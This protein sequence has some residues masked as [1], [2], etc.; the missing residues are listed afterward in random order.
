MFLHKR[1][2]SNSRQL[3]RLYRSR[4]SEYRMG[5]AKVGGKNF[6]SHSDIPSKF[7]TTVATH[8]AVLLIFATVGL[9]GGIVAWQVL[10]PSSTNTPPPMEQQTTLSCD[11]AETFHDAS[12]H[13][14]DVKNNHVVGAQQKIIHCRELL[15]K[16]KNAP[17]VTTPVAR[18]TM[19]VGKNANPAIGERP[20]ASPASVEPN[21][22]TFAEKRH[23]IPA[24]QAEQAGSNPMTTQDFSSTPVTFDENIVFHDEHDNYSNMDSIKNIGLAAL[25]VLAMDTAAP[26]QVDTTGYQAPDK[27]ETVASSPKDQSWKSQF[28]RHE[29]TLGVGDPSRVNY[30]R[31]RVGTKPN[32]YP[33]VWLQNQYH[34]GNIY[35]TCPITLGY[36]FRVLK[37]LWVGGDVSY[38]G[39]FGSFKDVYTDQKVGKYRDHFI[40]IMPA[41]R[42]SSLYREHFAMY[43]GIACGIAFEYSESYPDYKAHNNHLA[44][45]LTLLGFTAGNQRW[46]GFAEL[47][48]GYKGGYVN[49]GLGFRFNPKK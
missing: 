46:F 44:F 20:A 16:V 29:F 22:S 35:T 33:E 42:F 48:C 28:K 32:Y 15:P 38:C 6:S 14:T 37:W 26:A 40:S 21:A 41:V 17:M 39:F 10:R 9:I 13:M 8:K 12:P 43:S 4:L 23:T 25:M 31:N 36:R 18:P 24:G 3:D 49:A 34:I 2:N 19:P 45:Q 1:I 30:F 27:T 11:S 7:G 5:T 47:G